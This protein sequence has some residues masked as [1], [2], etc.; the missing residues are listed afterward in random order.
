MRYNKYR[1]K[2]LF[3]YNPKSGRCSVSK[4]LAYIRKRLET[5][6]EVTMYAT[7]SAEDLTEQVR[8]GAKEYDAIVFSGGDGT[9][10][11][12]L[13]GLENEDVQLGY[14]PAG[15]ANDVAR[16][17]G[18][19]RRLKGALNVVLKGRS[20]RLDCMRVNGTRYVMYVAAAGSLTS[21]TYQTPQKEKK[22]WG[23]FA[24]FFRGITRNLKLEVFPISGTCNGRAFETNGVFMFVM[25]GRSVAGF[26]VN[27][28]ASMQDGTLEVAIIKQALKPNLFRKIGAYFSLAAFMV[29]GLKVKKKDIEIMRGDHVCVNTHEKLVW[30]FDGEEGVA[31]DIEIE[32]MRRH[33]KLFVPK[34]KKV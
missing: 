6:Y 31:G 33:V 8:I 34:H 15:T 24:Y 2:C 29:V 16:S 18:I 30:D 22:L 26:P 23:W 27:K 20:E 21:V 9:F 10:N 4:N 32:V 3:L 11:R 13:Q 5:K 17:L 25:N 19:P 12:V 7:K 14:L 28:E 1:M